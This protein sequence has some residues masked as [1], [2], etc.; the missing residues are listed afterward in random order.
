TT[1]SSGTPSTW[2]E[3]WKSSELIITT[4]AFTSRSVAAPPENDLANRRPP[5]PPLPATLGGIIAAVFSRCRSRRNLRIRHGQGV[6]RRNLAV[7]VRHASTTISGCEQVSQTAAYFD[8]LV[9]A[10]RQ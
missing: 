4:I 7:A 1:C 8:R 5:L 10:A 3:N 9:G 6:D 2:S